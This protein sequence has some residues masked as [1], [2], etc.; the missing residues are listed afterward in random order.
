MNEVIEIVDPAWAH[1]MFLFD[2]ERAEHGRWDLYYIQP[3]LEAYRIG[4]ERLLA[5]STTSRVRTA[6]ANVGAARRVGGK[7]H[8]DAYRK[9]DLALVAYKKE[10]RR[11]LIH[12]ANGM[13]L[14]WAKDVT[15][16]T[17]RR[18]SASDWGAPNCG[19]EGCR[20]GDIASGRAAP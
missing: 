17:R 2:R 16:T 13:P 18:I 3:S 15:R 7:L 11:H 5:S 20:C 12:A 14:G 8:D 19:A 6:A 1:A 9:H 4:R 10:L